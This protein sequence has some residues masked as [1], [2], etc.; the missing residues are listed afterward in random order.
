M[1]SL[2]GRVARLFPNAGYYGWTI[3]VVG[4]FCS[5]LSSPGQSFAISLYIEHFIFD[6]G[7]SRVGVSSLYAAA[8]LVAAAALP[9]FGA[10]AD[11]VSARAYMLQCMA[12]EDRNQSATGSPHRKTR[13]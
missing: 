1:S 12:G 4:M 6:V 9:F 10:I 8:T 5:A 11:R 13:D 2:S 3:V 7:I